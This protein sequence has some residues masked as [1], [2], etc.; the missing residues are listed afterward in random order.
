[1]QRGSDSSATWGSEDYQAFWD[2]QPTRQTEGE[3]DGWTDGIE[4]SFSDDENAEFDKLTKKKKG[5]GIMYSRKTGNKL[6]KRKEYFILLYLYK[7]VRK[8]FNKYSPLIR[9]YRKCSPNTFRYTYIKTKQVRKFFNKIDKPSRVIFRGWLDRKGFKSGNDYMK[10]L[11]ALRGKS[12]SEQRAKWR[13]LRKARK[14]VHVNIRRF[15]M[16]RDSLYY[17]GKSRSAR[18]NLILKM[19]GKR[20]YVYERKRVLYGHTRQFLKKVDELYYARIAL[21]RYAFEKLRCNLRGFSSRHTRWKESRKKYNTLRRER[22]AIKR[23]L[24]TPK[25]LKKEYANRKAI[26]DAKGGYKE[27]RLQL[28]QAKGFKSFTDYQDHLAQRKGFSNRLEYE[29]FKRKE[30]E[31]LNGTRKD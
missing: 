29:A 1:M 26:W 31:V 22:R 17:T 24:K 23:K 10:S 7:Q 12:Y 6:S 18:R 20:K 5:R 16:L 13:M 4:I 8:F 21:G 11:Y 27:H 19:R 30:K 3:D 9:R 2:S 28:I 14:N 15:F 25:R